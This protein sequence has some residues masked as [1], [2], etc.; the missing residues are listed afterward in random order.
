MRRRA[1]PAYAYAYAY[2]Y[3]CGY[4]ALLVRALL[5]GSPLLLCFCLGCSAPAAPA[6]RG[7]RVIPAPVDRCQVDCTSWLKY[8]L[9]AALLAQRRFLCGCLA[10]E[11]SPRQAELRVLISTEGVAGVHL[12]RGPGQ[13]PLA[14]C[15]VRR[16]GRAVESWLKLRPGWFRQ[17]GTWAQRRLSRSWA[18]ASSAVHFHWEGLACGPG[19]RAADPGE[20]RLPAPWIGAHPD[21]LVCRVFDCA[22]S[23]T[24]CRPRNVMWQFP[25]ISGAGPISAR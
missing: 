4:G 24:S 9:A 5:A 18:R 1:Q 17:G 6:S 11:S 12:V 3:V 23:P 8:S 7:P 20:P 21:G 22:P 15:L 13:A 16:T 19:D 10:G 25:L 2:A 14:S